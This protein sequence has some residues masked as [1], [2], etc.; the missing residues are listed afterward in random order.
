[1]EKIKQ[2]CGSNMVYCKMLKLYNNFEM[3]IGARHRLVVE[4]KNEQ[5]KFLKFLL[6]ELK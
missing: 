4:D 6:A 5:E 2:L 3:P 1:M